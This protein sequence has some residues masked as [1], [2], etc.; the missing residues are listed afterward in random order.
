[1]AADRIH[2][3]AHVVHARFEIGHAERSVRETGT[4]LVEPDQARNR[5]ESFEEVRMTRLLPVLL[6]VGDEARDEH[7]VDRAVAGDLVGD[8]EVAAARVA[9]RRMPRCRRGRGGLR[10]R[11]QAR[12]LTEDLQL[13]LLERRPR[14][15]AEL[16]DERAASAPEDLEGIGLPATAVEREHQLAPQTL[17][18]HVL[19]D[20]RLELRHQ[21]VMAAERQLGVDAILDRREPQLLEPSDLALRECLAL[22][23]GQRLAPPERQ[24]VAQARRPLARIVALAGP[25][26][27]RLEPGEVDLVRRRLQQITGRARPDPLGADQLAKARDMPVQRGLRRSRRLLSPQC[28]DQLGAAHDLL[29]TQE[30][31]REQRPLLG[32]R[33]GHIAATL[34]NPQRTKQLEFHSCRLSHALARR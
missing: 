1:V 6:E 2:D 14:V 9:D 4:A 33:R 26:D 5:A 10:R 30:Q 21:L 32:T 12:V 34:D 29:A 11:L 31:H 22:E 28:L 3:R 24:R 25:R 27:Q 7:E 17:A 13:E 23:V 15:D 8:V 16:L 19:C 20:Q 18:K